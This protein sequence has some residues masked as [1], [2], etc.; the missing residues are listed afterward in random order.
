MSL[1]E[2]EEKGSTNG[3]VIYS[4]PSS[5]YDFIVVALAMAWQVTTLDR[6]QADVPCIP[7]GTVPSHMA[8]CSR[9]CS[10]ACSKMNGSPAMVIRAGDPIEENEELDKAVR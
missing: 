6:A 4:A 2:F 1:T 10:D 3:S 5:E 9:S 7:R 8:T